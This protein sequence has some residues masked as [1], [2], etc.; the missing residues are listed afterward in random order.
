M[1]ELE[2]LARRGDEAKRRHDERLRDA[3]ERETKQERRQRE[4]ERGFVYRTRPLIQLARIVGWGSL[5]TLPLGG[6]LTYGFST[7][8]GPPFPLGA[9]IF[10]LSNLA[11]GVIGVPLLVLRPR[12]VRRALARERSRYRGFSVEGWIETLGDD[13]TYSGRFIEWHWGR[14]IFAVTMEAPPATTLLQR[15]LHAIDAGASVEH[16]GATLRFTSSLCNTGG[17]AY[18][19]GRAVLDKLLPALQT[20]RQ[21]HHVVVSRDD[22]WRE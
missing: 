4:L 5:A 14:I 8:S 6:M 19:W 22:N 11:L 3:P 9:W 21:V 2:E 12:L 7:A 18:R 16:S 17:E 20:E 10:A 13:W 15:A 1:G